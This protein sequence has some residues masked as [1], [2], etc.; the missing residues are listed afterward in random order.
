[1]SLWPEYW[2]CRVGREWGEVKSVSRLRGEE[3]LRDLGVEFHACN[4]RT[5][6]LEAGRSG[7]Q[8]QFQIQNVFGAREMIP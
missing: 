1:M 7:V 3:R 2:S 8:S 4:P 6:E 5:Q